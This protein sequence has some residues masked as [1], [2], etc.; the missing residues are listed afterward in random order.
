MSSKLGRSLLTRCVRTC[1]Q[2]KNIQ[3]DARLLNTVALRRAPTTWCVDSAFISNISRQS[4]RCY[5]E[6]PAIHSRIEGLVAGKPLVVFM[7][8]TPAQPMCGFSN[9]VCQI[10]RMHGVPP[11]DS[12]N[13]LEDEELRQGIKEYSNWPTIPQVSP[14]LG[15]RKAKIVS[16]SI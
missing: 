13:V 5:S 1:G 6:K 9:A 12:Y 4:I 2:S 16:S 7:K 15:V 8:G 11:F 14:D 3:T 10:L